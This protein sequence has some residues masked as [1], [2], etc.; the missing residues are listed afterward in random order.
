MM[1]SFLRDHPSLV[2]VGE[3]ALNIRRLLL[4]LILALVSVHAGQAGA[5]GTLPAPQSEAQCMKGFAP[6]RE[7]WERRG[8]LIKA[9]S[10]RHAPPDEAC[11]LISDFRQAETTMIK[12]IEANSAACRI[13][14]QVAEQLKGGHKDTEALQKKVCG[15]AEQGGPVNLSE[16]L[17]A[18]TL[19]RKSAGP[20]GDFEIYR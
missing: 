4:P 10:A 1:A 2:L 15:V 13:P 3:T 19:V 8:K 14:P 18:A 16:M 17:G 7:E 11:K 9:A 5:Q 6:L 20:V 12:Y